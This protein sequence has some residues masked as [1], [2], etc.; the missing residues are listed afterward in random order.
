MTNP[1]S[2]NQTLDEIA[3]TLRY[4]RRVGVAGF[5]CSQTSLA[6]LEDWGKPKTGRPE[7]LD[8]IRQDLG[9]CRRCGLSAS[10]N[11]IVFG[12]G[13]P[14]ARLVFVGE[15]PGFE[16]DRSG[17][18]FVG[19]A[20]GLLTRIIEAI[21]LRREDVYICNVIKCRPPNNR[22]PEPE[23]IQTCAPFLMRQLAVIRPLFVCALGKFA[24]QTLLNSTLPISKLRG[25]FYDF[26]GMRLIP[27]YHPAFLL[28]NADRKRDVWEDMKL[29]MKEYPYED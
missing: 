19:A 21:R 1:S 22:N 12:E 14:T 11:H 24:A 10:R 26:A 5:E 9:D 17:R 20:G 23:E 4:L 29:L 8:G 3:R 6:V 15:G 13:S 28:R 25:R 7:T 27:T 16:E 18:P 2:L